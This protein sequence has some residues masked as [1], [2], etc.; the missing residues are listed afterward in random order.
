MD[1]AR[2]RRLLRGGGPAHRPIGNVINGD[3]LGAPSNLPWATAYTNAN[4]V[5]QP[6]YYLGV[7]YQP[8]AVYEALGTIVIGLLL[9]LLRRRKVRPGV[10]IISY[11]AL[12]A[13]SQLLL[14]FLRQS[15][16]VIWLGLK[17]L[18]LTSIAALVVGVPLL[19]LVWLRTEGRTGSPGEPATPEGDLAPA[20]TAEGEPSE[21]ATT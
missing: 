10:V 9:V 4:A 5:L 18:Q 21:A 11:V 19:I 1:G 17:Q 14:D 7:A 6:H 8:A 3:I 16:P 15:E 2:R 13:L 20:A 12:Y